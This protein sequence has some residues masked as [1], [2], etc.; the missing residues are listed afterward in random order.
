MSA[1]DDLKEKAA[2]DLAIAIVGYVEAR[3]DEADRLYLW[4]SYEEDVED[5]KENGDAHA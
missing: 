1:F 3:C 4:G 5:Y 2:N